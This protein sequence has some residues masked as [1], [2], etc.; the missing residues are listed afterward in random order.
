MERFIFFLSLIFLFFL[1]KGYSADY[2]WVG[3]SGDWSDISHW[4]TSSGGTVKYSVT[5]SA[6]D[7][8]FFDENSFPT[9]GALV[10]INNDIAFASNLT[11]RNIS[12]NPTIRAGANATLNIYGSL[13][14]IPQMTFQFGGNIH[15]LGSTTTRSIN[16]ANHNAAANILFNGTGSWNL[17]SNLIVGNLLEINQGTISFG[18][19]QVTTQFFKSSSNLQRVIN[20]DNAR[21]RITGIS[22]FLSIFWLAD[23]RNKFTIHINSAN[24]SSTSNGARIE[25]SSAFNH[26]YVSNNGS[27]ELPAILASSTFGLT[28]I[29]NDQK[30]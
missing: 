4:A 9:S 21:F 18:N 26:L 24:W 3:G 1:P 29:I 27:I 6:S 11:F 8:V 16:F 13:A 5:P 10:T 20:F 12:T 23:P 22:D 7:N 25:V 30:I 15:F 19:N 14:L 17:L 28:E 2:Y